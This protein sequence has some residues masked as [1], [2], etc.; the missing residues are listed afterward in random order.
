MIN[1]RAVKNAEIHKKVTWYRPHERH[2]HGFLGV[3]LIMFRSVIGSR[4]L[5]WNLFKR[6]FLAAYKKSFIGFSWIFIIPLLGVLQWI[7][8]H[9]AGML[10]PGVTE[11][12]YEVYVLV[13]VTM[14][15]LFVGLFNAAASTL[16]AGQTIVMQVKYPHEA[17]LFKEA[18]QQLARFIISF[19][20]VLIVL[21]VFKVVPHWTTLL[22]PIVVLPMFFLA[23]SIGLV[24]SMLAVV[25]VGIRMLIHKGAALLMW[26]TPLVFVAPA[27]NRIVPVIN[28]WNPLQ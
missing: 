18:L 26:A 10:N 14:W 5:I 9:R 17:F 4:T 28:K 27:A 2:E 25:A 19:V 3:W 12:P 22:L 15:G 23:A 6:D 13:G 21:A 16:T 8:L 11:G 1:R 24:I 7:F 20:L